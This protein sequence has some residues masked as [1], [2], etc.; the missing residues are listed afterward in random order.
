MR[1]GFIGHLQRFVG[2]PRVRRQV[3]FAR[4]V[5]LDA[6]PFADGDGGQEI[7][8]PVEDAGAGLPEA[9]RHTLPIPV[10]RRGL[11]AGGRVALRE[12]RQQAQR[13]RGAEHLP[14][15]T[16]HLIVQA[17]V[18]R[19]FRAGTASR[20]MRSPPGSSTRWKV[21]A[22]RVSPKAVTGLDV[23]STRAP[24]GITTCSAA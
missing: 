9:G 11:E 6:M 12:T 21:T 24:A 10:V 22:K 23:P 5:D 4:H 3:E 1:R 20:S 2:P 19:G 14:V 16:V 15:V 18:A 13:D 8:E 7:E 17:Q